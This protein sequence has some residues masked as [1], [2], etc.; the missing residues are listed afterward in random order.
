M[1]PLRA[2]AI[3]IVV[4]T[5][6]VFFAFA[7]DI[8]FTKGYEMKAV[9]QNSSALQLNSPVR[10][11]GVDVGKV[12]KVEPLSGDS[13][14][15]EVTMKIDEKGLPIHRDARLK[16]RPRIFLEG[17]FFVDVRPGTPGSPGPARR[18]HHRPDADLGAGPAGPGAGHAQVHRA[19]RT[20]RSCSRAT[21]SPSTASPP[22]PRTPRRTPTRRAR[23]RRSR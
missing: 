7:K 22:R 10:I 11:A 16:I 14:L 2:G 19:R 21:A 4:L 18:R 23:P 20:C 15:T 3:G 8:P 9:F 13:T 1:T 17:N 5:V 6:F 12:S